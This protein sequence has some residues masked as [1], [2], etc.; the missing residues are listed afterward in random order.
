MAKYANPVI[1]GFYPDPSVVKV[2]KNDYYLVTSSFEYFPGVPIFH[3]KDLIHWEQIGSVLHNLDLTKC[4]SSQGVYAPTLRY[5]DG[6]FYMITTDVMGE[7]N[8]YV[9]AT[10]PR[11]PWSEP[12]KIPYGNI[13]PSLMFDDDGK[14]YVSVQNSEG[15]DSHIIQYEIDI[16]TGEALSEP[17]VVCR[18]DG[19]VWTEAP[20]LYKINGMYYLLCACGGTG[21]DHRAIIARSKDVYGPYDLYDR[22]ILT[23]NQLKDHPLQNLGHADFVEDENGNWW[24]VFLGVR[25]VNQEYGVLGRETFLAPVTWTEDGWPMMD[26]NEGTVNVIMETDA[27]PADV[28]FQEVYTVRDDFEGTELSPSWLYLRAKKDEDYSLTERPGWMRLL[29]NADHLNE[30]GVPAFICKPQEQLTMETSTLLDFNPEQDGEEA[31]LVARLNE[32]AHYEV[33]VKRLDGQ[34]VVVATTT[35]NG[36]T[37]EVSRHPFSGGL[38]RLAISSDKE[39]YYLKFAEVDGDWVELGQAPASSLS[40]EKNGGYASCFTG[41]CIGPYASGNGKRSVT[42]AYF[43][44]VNFVG[45]VVG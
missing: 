11:G 32:Y 8:F 34:T 29:G 13:D 37:E 28:D 24:A 33:T 19:G 23:H 16:T 17:V 38:V 43:D 31:G 9:S 3:S 27:L 44:Y 10:D 41:V 5:H 2:G 21:D 30:I 12:I 26:N 14:V 42:P 15:A 22:P 40:P 25:F 6:T 36:V 35:I 39:T 20:H 7:G 4:R 1:P 45:K 18:G